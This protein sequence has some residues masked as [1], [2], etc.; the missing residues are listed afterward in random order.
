MVWF[1]WGQRFYCLITSRTS[2]WDSSTQGHLGF[3]S[4]VW[5]LKNDLRENELIQFLDWLMEKRWT[6]HRKCDFQKGSIDVLTIVFFFFFAWKFSIVNCL[7]MRGKHRSKAAACCNGGKLFFH[8]TM[9]CCCSCQRRTSTNKSFYLV[10]WSKKQKR[11][12]CRGRASE[13]ICKCTRNWLDQMTTTNRI[14][15]SQALIIIRSKRNT[16]IIRN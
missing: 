6:P 11:R 8:G 1:V 10:V 15:L 9:D 13:R 5:S 12:H 3:L 16:F 2:S 4:A 7:S 14:I